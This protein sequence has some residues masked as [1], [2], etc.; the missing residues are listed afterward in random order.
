MSG[1]IDVVSGAAE[2]DKSVAVQGR[3][4]V[5]NS[6]EMRTALANALRAKPANVSARSVRRLVHRHFRVSHAG[7]GGP[8]CPQAGH[9]ADPERHARSASLLL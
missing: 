7:G 9:A 2:M 8:D 4:T 3:I 5:S 1:E 6:G